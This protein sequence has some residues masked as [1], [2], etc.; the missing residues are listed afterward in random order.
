MTEG[1]TGQSCAR[2]QG[3]RDNNKFRTMRIFVYLFSLLLP[4]QKACRKEP[5]PAKSSEQL[6]L[7]EQGR[8]THAIDSSCMTGLRPL[9]IEALLKNCT[10]YYRPFSNSRALQLTCGSKAHRT[11]SLPAY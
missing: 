3:K 1:R 2:S 4:P 9:S 8:P 6:R 11:L 10:F 5:S 7:F